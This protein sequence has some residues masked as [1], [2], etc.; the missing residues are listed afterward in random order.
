LESSRRSE[1]GRETIF[2]AYFVIWRGGDAIVMME[3]PA[4]VLCI[5]DEEPALLLRRLV[6]ERAG[7]RVFWALSG[8]EGIERFRYQPTDVVIVDYWMAGM[9]GLEVAKAIKAM[10]SRTPIIMLSGFTT[11]LDEG[12]GKV[13]LWLRKGDSNPEQLLMAVVHMLDKRREKG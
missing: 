13:D 2:A 8:R 7:Y 10:S 11:I 6:L 1:S 3:T 12:L 5:D 9:N 4:S